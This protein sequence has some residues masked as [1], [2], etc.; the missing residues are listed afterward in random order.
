[1]KKKLIIVLVIILLIVGVGCCFYF[2]SLGPVSSSNKIVTFTISSGTGKKEIIDS[3]KNKGLIKNKLALYMHIALNRNLN[4]Q[5]G[6]YE[7]SPNMG[8]E[9]I[10]E[11]LNDGK[12]KEED[13]TFNLTFIEG[14]RFPYYVKKIAEATNSTEEEV[15]SSL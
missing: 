3:L 12:I 10:L 5:A 6:T 13:N 15:M 1:M 8:A 7:L 9:K 14:K 2:Y 4:L 11:I